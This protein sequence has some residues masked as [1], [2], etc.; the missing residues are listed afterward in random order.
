MLKTEKVVNKIIEALE[1]NKAHQIVKVDLRKIENCFCRFFVICHGT[2]STHIAGLA[3]A[4]E[5]KVRED[6]DE[7][8]LHIE[9]LHTAQWVVLDYAD[10]IVHIFDKEQRDYYQL[11]EF[12]ADAKITEIVEGREEKTPVRS[13]R[14][15]KTMEI[16]R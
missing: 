9:G 7:R 10:V 13:G 2:S 1:D 15:T 4:V 14:K 12:W 3:D 11:E 8:P 5:D 6:L 16:V